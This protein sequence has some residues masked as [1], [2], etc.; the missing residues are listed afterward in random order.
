[1]DGRCVGAQL[2]ECQTVWLQTVFKDQSLDVIFGLLEQAALTSKNLSHWFSQIFA[3][4]LP[5]NPDRATSILVQMMQN[6]SYETSQTAAGPDR[7]RT[8]ETF[9]EIL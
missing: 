8:T 6:D 1:M 4:V 5:A 2:D 7:V 9:S 3:R